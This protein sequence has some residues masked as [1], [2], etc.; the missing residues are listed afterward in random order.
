M[1]FIFAVKRC[2]TIYQFKNA[3]SKTRDQATLF[4]EEA[5]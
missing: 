3:Y 5:I 1:N 4:S 2:K